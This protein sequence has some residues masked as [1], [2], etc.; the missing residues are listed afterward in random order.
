[1]ATAAL[2]SGKQ[3]KKG[4]LITGSVDGQ[5]N[6]GPVG[7]VLE[8]AEAA[9]AGGFTT[10]LVPRGEA[11]TQVPIEVCTE[12]QTGTALI[13]SCNTTYEYKKVADLTGIRIIEVDDVSQAY[14]LMVQ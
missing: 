14:G 6:I 1:M 5:G 8:K 9:K 13:K 11:T 10:F 4:F 3:L 7:R 12:K 2:V